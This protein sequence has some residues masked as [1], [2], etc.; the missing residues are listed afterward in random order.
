MKIDYATNHYYF[1]NISATKAW[2]SMKFEIL[3]HKLGKV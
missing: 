2:I 3:S 1:T